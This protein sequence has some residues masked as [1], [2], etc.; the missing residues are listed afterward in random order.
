M[1]LTILVSSYSLLSGS[2][3]PYNALALSSWNSRSRNRRSA[4][5]NWLNAKFLRC[6]NDLAWIAVLL[7]SDGSAAVWCIELICGLSLI[8][9]A[10]LRAACVVIANFDAGPLWSGSANPWICAF[11]LEIP[12]GLVTLRDCSNSMRSRW[13]I[14]WKKSMINWGTSWKNSMLANYLNLIYRQ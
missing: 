13:V 8:P 11:W 5:G 3:T 12:V 2:Y 14:C 9:P 6:L 10:M 4:A 7:H 1:L